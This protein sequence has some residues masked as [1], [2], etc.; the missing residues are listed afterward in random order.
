M[1]LND[2]CYAEAFRIIDSL[3]RRAQKIIR[4]GMTLEEI[5][6]SDGMRLAQY[7]EGLVNR[8]QA[9]LQQPESKVAPQGKA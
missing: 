7:A 6:I 8:F 3:F 1:E 4:P 2:V 5:R 9:F